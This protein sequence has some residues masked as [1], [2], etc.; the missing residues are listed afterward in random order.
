MPPLEAGLAAAVL[1][2]PVL[3]CAPTAELAARQ[4]AEPEAVAAAVCREIRQ[5]PG[6]T[7]RSTLSTGHRKS[8]TRRASTTTAATSGVRPP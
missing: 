4:A 6:S 2:L 8:P 7:A 5:M 3:G 1:V